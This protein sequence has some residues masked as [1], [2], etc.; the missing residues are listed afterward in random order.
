MGLGLSEWGGISK[1]LAEGL[2]TYIQTQ[3]I[4]QET[5]IKKRLAN[6]QSVDAYAKLIDVAGTDVANQEKEHLGLMPNP[7]QGLMTSKP[8]S[9]PLQSMG[10]GGA[11]EAA[12]IS[13]QGGT[14]INSAGSQDLQS[15]PPQ[16]QQGL[17]QGL[18]TPEF[19]SSEQK[20]AMSLPSKQRGLI[21]EPLQKRINEQ[22]ERGTPTGQLAYQK[23]QTELANQKLSPQFQ[24][25]NEYDQQDLTKNARMAALNFEKLRSADVKSPLSGKALVYN[26][27]GIE[28]PGVAPSDSKIQDL[29]KN[30]N[31][32]QETVDWLAKGAQGYPT[33]ETLNDFKRAGAVAMQGVRNAQRPMQQDYSDR[34]KLIG[35]NQDFITKDSVLT[36]ADANAAGLLKK[37]GPYQSTAG[38][39]M[40]DTA[41]GRMVSNIVDKGSKGIS[42]IGKGLL[43]NM[44]PDNPGSSAENAPP[45]V[46]DTEDGYKY[47]GGNPHDHKNWKKVK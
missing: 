34:A 8:Q 16:Q 18:L 12:H 45:E 2:Q 39:V 44:S 20:R 23:S 5:A 25:K 13:P 29:Q 7:N 27:L 11:E 26:Y 14:Y 30:P 22:T 19:I 28:Q 36:N 4:L 47:M 9:S 31:F 6:A 41:P 35:A 21:L 33:V 3:N 15:P 37:L 10:P 43:Q 24:L 1:G 46:G 38:K 17:E 32:S 42:K 40:T